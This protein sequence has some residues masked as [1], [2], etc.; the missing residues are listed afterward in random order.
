[1]N[2]QELIN[3]YNLV[4]NKTWLNEDFLTENLKI[5]RSLYTDD[6]LLNKKPIT[7][8]LH[9]FAYLYGI[10]FNSTQ[11]N[12]LVGFQN[13][14]R[15][16]IGD[17]LAYFVIPEN[18]GLE[19]A[20]L[21]W[22]EE[23]LVEGKIQKSIDV[24]ASLFQNHHHS[25][26]IINGF[27]IN[28]D[29]CIVARGIDKSEQFIPFRK[30][31]MEVPDLFPA[32]QSGWIH[33]PIGRILEPVGKKIFLELK[34]LVENSISATEIDFGNPGPLKFVEETQW[35]MEELKLIQEFK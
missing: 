5:S 3:S 14:I 23:N 27:Q 4:H 13:S 19:M 9:V 22:P 21:K 28:P 26:I 1:M 11:K 32:R 16:L 15:Q 29:G 33:I 8:K 2:K 17:T 35:Y 20:V 10:S 6:S 31:L 12:I 25:E 30:Q 24:V 18:L 34:T 7:K